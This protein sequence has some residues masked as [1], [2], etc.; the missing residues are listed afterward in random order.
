MDFFWTISLTNES[1][2]QNVSRNQKDFFLEVHIY[3]SIFTL[4]YNMGVL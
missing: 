3:I 2:L 1:E 4:Y